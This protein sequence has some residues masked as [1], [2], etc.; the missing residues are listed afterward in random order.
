MFSKLFIH[1]TKLFSNLS[2]V[3]QLHRQKVSKAW[4]LYR[5]QKRIR[6][7]SLGNLPKNI[8]TKG[9]GFRKSDLK[10][11]KST[12]FG[13]GTKRMEFQLVQT[14]P[15]IDVGTGGTWGT[16]PSKILQ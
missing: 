10:S 13:S 5:F 14:L 3:Y 1:K 15:A 12:F 16:C 4:K 9:V 7:K 6:Q 2:E 11:T 8:M